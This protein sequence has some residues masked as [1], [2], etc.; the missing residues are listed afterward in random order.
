MNEI[1]NK[2]LYRLCK[3]YGRNALMWRRKFIGLLPEVNRRH[4]YEKKGF[5]SIFEFAFKLAGL[6]EKQVRLALNLEERFKDKPVLHEALISGQISTNKLT[7]IASIAT[8]ENETFWVEKAKQLPK[9]ALETLIRDAKNEIMNGLN[10]QEN[11]KKSLPGQNLA[12]DPEI[13]EELLELQGKGIDV[14]QMLREF[15]EKRR[16]EIAEEKEELAVRMEYSRARSR[17]IPAKV[18]RLLHKEHGSICSIDACQKPAREIHH[19]QRYALTKNHNP[20]YLA[21]LCRE[22]HKI[23]HAI[24]VKAL[25]YP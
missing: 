25:G 23:A 22:H 19:S 8:P 3:K 2:A 18:R 16:Q 4:L 7:R 15:L 1:S 10:K 17:Y 21:P 5:N 6:S 13:E 11:G 14:N 24:D 20:K 9:S 12:L